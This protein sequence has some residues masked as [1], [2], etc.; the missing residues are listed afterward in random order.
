MKQTLGEFLREYGENLPKNVLDGTIRRV[1]S[2]KGRTKIWVET[3][4]PQPL[5]FAELAPVEAEI[6]SRLGLGLFRVLGR[7]PA[8]TFCAEVLPDLFENLKRDLQQFTLQGLETYV[9]SKYPEYTNK[10]EI[11]ERVLH[12][13]RS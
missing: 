4:Y 3:E 5:K 12:R 13:K 6:A 11:F 9:Y 10:S 8:E 7:Y 1:L 2:D